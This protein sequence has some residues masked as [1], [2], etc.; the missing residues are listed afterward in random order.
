MRPEGERTRRGVCPW[1]S[2]PDN[3]FSRLRTYANRVYGYLTGA[4]I[5]EPWMIFRRHPPK[6]GLL[7]YLTREFIDSGFQRA[8]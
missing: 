3:R 5:V 7:E 6:P 8:H 2:T 1:I 4:G